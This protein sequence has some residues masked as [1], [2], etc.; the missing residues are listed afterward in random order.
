MF[1][2]PSLKEEDMKI[3]TKILFI[4]LFIINQ[5]YANGGKASLDEMILHHEE[6]LKKTKKAKKN[7]ELTKDLDKIFSE[8]I[9]SQEKEIKRLKKIRKNFYPSIKEASKNMTNLS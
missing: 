3:I 6:G 4:C 7:D 2:E 5:S 9:A 1:S 8:M